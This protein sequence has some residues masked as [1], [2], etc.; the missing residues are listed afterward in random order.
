[1]A[2]YIDNNALLYIKQKVL[3]SIQAAISE[4]DLFSG[5]WTDLRDRPSALSQFENDVNF[6]TGQQVQ[7]AITA[8]VAAL[9]LASFA[10][11]ANFVTGSQVSEFVQNAL[12]QISTVQFARVS[13]LPEIS[14]ASER[15]IYLL[16]DGD[17]RDENHY[18]QWLAVEGEW[19]K[20]G[21][22]DI[23]LSDYLKTTDMMAVT[24]EEIDAI[25]NG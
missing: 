2:R 3:G 24:N 21:D 15:T 10:N 19:L 4:L 5:S 14:E 12:G 20:I 6:R 1:M 17:A 23:D 11:D 22:T 8:A 13:A 18:E 16:P 9:T 25:W 7:A